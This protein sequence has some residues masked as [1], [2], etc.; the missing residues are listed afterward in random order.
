M[1]NWDFYPL[2]ILFWA[3]INTHAHTLGYYFSCCITMTSKSMIN[4]TLKCLSKLDVYYQKVVIGDHITYQ[5]NF[6]T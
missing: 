4:L 1:W 6:H 5:I 2:F 3:N